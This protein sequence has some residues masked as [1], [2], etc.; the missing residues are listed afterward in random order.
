MDKDRKRELREEF[1]K[2][3]VMYGVCQLKNKNS[4]K[5]FLDSSPNMKNYQLRLKLQLDMGTHANKELQTDWKEQG[6]DAFLYS[7]LQ[8]EDAGKVTDARFE[9]SLLLKTWL[10]KLAESEASL[11]NKPARAKQ[12]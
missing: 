11:Y 2:V 12:A 4:G 6:E 7:E 9:A 5:A 1:S 3:P 8:L 10:A